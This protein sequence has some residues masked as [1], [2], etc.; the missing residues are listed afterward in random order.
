LS[1]VSVAMPEFIKFGMKKSKHFSFL[2]EFI[3]KHVVLMFKA[4]D[5]GSVLVDERLNP[6][7]K[8]GIFMSKVMNGMFLII[9]LMTI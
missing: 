5:K 9:N 4:L 8:A 6:L 7:L 1:D 2:C 3:F